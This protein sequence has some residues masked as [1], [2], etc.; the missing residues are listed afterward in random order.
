MNII[1]ISING[2]LFNN[3]KQ[4][5]TFEG[6]VYQALPFE[7]MYSMQN[8]NLQPNTTNIR[9]IFNSIITDE[10]MVTNFLYKSEI[11]MWDIM[12]NIKKIT[13][14]GMAFDIKTYTSGYEAIVYGENY[15]LTAPLTKQ[16]SEKC[17]AT[18]CDSKC[19][20]NIQ[21]HTYVGVITA[22]RSHSIVLT[23][24]LPNK[25]WK[26]STMIF[27]KNST[28]ALLT[29]RGV[30]GNEVLFLDPTHSSIQSG[31]TV[32]F[33]S[34]CNKTLKTCI[35]IYNNAVNF[36]GEPFIWRKSW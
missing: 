35:E 7:V 33:Q 18:F 10:E 29:V 14:K 8:A 31:D 30:N 5:I 34:A 24:S 20:L 6:Q 36:R 17:R 19:S 27:V 25:F 16:Y 15:K 32:S 4:A 1:F 11:I 12:D 28:K 9:F 26:N 3:S 22:V 23:A 2:S 21:N 13:F